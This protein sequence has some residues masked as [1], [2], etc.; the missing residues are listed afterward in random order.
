M[1]RILIVDDETDIV[2]ILSRLLGK[3]GHEPI[4]TADSSEA[5]KMLD[6]EQFDRALRGVPEHFE[7]IAQRGNAVVMLDYDAASDTWVENKEAGEFLTW[8]KQ[9]REETA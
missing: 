8:S 5:A 6:Q 3:K 7:T 9:R 4:A 1:G 2:S